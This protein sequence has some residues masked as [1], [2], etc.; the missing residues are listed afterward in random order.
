MGE[1][2]CIVLFA[3]HNW[4]GRGRV[5]GASLVFYTCQYEAAGGGALLARFIMG[6]SEGVD[7]FSKII[8]AFAILARTFRF[9]AS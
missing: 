1:L 9:L 4:V 6:L 5:T 7:V 3:G 2:Y 8:S